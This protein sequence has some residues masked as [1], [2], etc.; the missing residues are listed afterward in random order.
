[1]GSP[2]D[3]FGFTVGPVN[4][5]PGT[6][7]QFQPFSGMNSVIIKYFSGGSLEFGGVS[8]ASGSGYLMAPNEV[9]Q[10]DNRG[11]FY[12]TATG[13]TVTIMLIAGVSG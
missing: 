8:F 4:L 12:L 2:S 7:T 3:I 6:C 5:A 11:T 1:M 13:S 9:L 10:F